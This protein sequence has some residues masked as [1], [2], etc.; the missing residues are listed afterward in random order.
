MS[1]LQKEDEGRK[2]KLLE[3][4]KK[5]MEQAEYNS[6]LTKEEISKVKKYQKY[7][8]F[9]QNGHWHLHMGQMI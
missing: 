7:K 2:T 3:E 4:F 9:V 8:T 1:W 5:A 6:E